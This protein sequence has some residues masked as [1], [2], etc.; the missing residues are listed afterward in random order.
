MENSC[1][2]WFS[3]LNF[4]NVW[5]NGSHFENSIIFGFLG[6]FEGSNISISFAPVFKVPK[7][8]VEWEV[9][10]I[11]LFTILFTPVD[12]I[13]NIVTDEPELDKSQVSF[14]K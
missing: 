13:T 4:Q 2:I 14:D 7:F 10:N 5:L 11:T 3:P 1:S 12:N 9:P 8:L 6:T